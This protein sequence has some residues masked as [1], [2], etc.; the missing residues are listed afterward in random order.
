MI[1]LFKG[2]FKIILSFIFYLFPSLLFFSIFSLFPLLSPF[3]QCLPLLPNLLYFFVFSFNDFASC[4]FLSSSPFHYY[5]SPL[6]PYL[7]FLALFCHQCHWKLWQCQRRLWDV[8]LLPGHPQFPV[9][10]QHVIPHRL[11]HGLPHRH[12]HQVHTPQG[13][14]AAGDGALCPHVVLYLPHGRGSGLDR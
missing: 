9:D 13:L 2:I 3:F 1:S 4:L 8:S 12:P 11:S 14:P 5:F 6:L 7:F 10:L